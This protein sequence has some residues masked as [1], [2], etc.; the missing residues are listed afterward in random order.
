MDRMFVNY[1][2]KFQKN[3]SESDDLL[4]K[5]L[6]LLTNKKETMVSNRI[7]LAIDSKGI[8]LCSST[9]INCME[10]DTLDGKYIE[11]GEMP[12]YILDKIYSK[13]FKITYKDSL[14]L[15]YVV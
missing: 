2:F 13:D 6:A 3:V 14:I 5:G 4:L 7:Y 9:V 1:I 11:R 8:W 15:D 12:P 10:T